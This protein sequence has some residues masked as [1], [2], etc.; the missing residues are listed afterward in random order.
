[1][2]I[3]ETGL[4]FWHHSCKPMSCY[5]KWKVFISV[6]TVKKF[7]FYFKTLLLLL[8]SQYTW[9]KFCCNMLHTQIFSQNLVT[10]GFW[11][12]NF[13]SYFPHCQRSIWMDDFTNF[14]GM[15]IFWRGRSS[16]TWVIF[17][18]STAVFKL[19]VPLVTLNAAHGCITK[20][21]L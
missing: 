14:F 1:M 17:S 20:C 2:S 21:L 10:R 4:L 8:V 6:S 11:T 16:R 9:H 19:F 3:V 5:L 18:Q 12:A 13:I 7:L 15:F